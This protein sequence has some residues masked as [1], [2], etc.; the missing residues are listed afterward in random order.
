MS[1]L[2][3]E[4]DK[5]AKQFKRGLLIEEELHLKVADTMKKLNGT[6]K[7]YWAFCDRHHLEPLTLVFDSEGRL[8]VENYV[9]S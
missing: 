2:I 1:V 6:M 5:F 7:D 4:L 9:F 3:M 8:L